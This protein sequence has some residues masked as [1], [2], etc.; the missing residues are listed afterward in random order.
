MTESVSALAAKRKNL[1]LRGRVIAAARLFFAREGYLEV[2]TPL[3]VATPA[4][5]DHIDAEASGDHWLRTSPELHM[6]RMVCAGYRKIYQIGPCFRRGERGTRHLPEYTMLEWYHT[7]VT[8]R[9]LI[10]ET[11]TLLVT[12]AEALGQNEFD[13]V[14]ITLPPVLFT[15]RDAFW[16]WAGW[17]PI[18]D[19]DEA[20]FDEDLVD[21]VEPMLAE[22][23]CPVILSDF[24]AERAALARLSPQNPRVAERWEMYIGGVELANAYSELTD[25]EEQRRR[26][27]HCAEGRRLRG[28]DVYPMDEPFLRALAVG[29]PPCAGIA[30]GLERLLMLLAGADDIRQVVPFAQP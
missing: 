10:G 8:C 13:G 7:G 19:F 9:E 21:K 11:H 28:Q 23:P 15:V 26:F 5:E 2:H 1:E 27:E 20:R 4:L 18:E 3:R 12:V 25:A 29:M 24:P 14:D 22:Q 30:L 6:K 17:D 16:L